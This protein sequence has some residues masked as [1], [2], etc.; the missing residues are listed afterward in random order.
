MKVARR[1]QITIPEDVREDLGLNVGDSVD[2]RSKE[3]KVVVEKM[4][5]S[6]E[7]VMAETRGAWRTHPVFKDMKDS[8]E[9]V[10]W[11]KEKKR[12]R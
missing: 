2:V 1:Y 3:G 7:T 8:V 6:W 12:K 9:I 11:L 4:D 5:R 10:D